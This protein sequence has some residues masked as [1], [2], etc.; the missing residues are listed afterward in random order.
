MPDPPASCTCFARLALLASPSQP[1]T[2]RSFY[3]CSW[4]PLSLSLCFHMVSPSS[5][6][7]LASP[8]CS[9]WHSAFLCVLPSLLSPSY[10]PILLALQSA[11]F[12]AVFHH[13]MLF[14]AA[15]S[16]AFFGLLR[17]REFTCSGPFDPRIHLF[18]RYF[19]HSFRIGAAISAADCER[20]SSPYLNC[21]S[22]V[23]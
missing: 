18:L 3:R 4:C 2:P 9:S 5:P 15:S 13:C 17:V 14:W 6:G 10:P 16:L 22:P 20:S 7:Y 12:L 8:S 23:P 1:A 21:W 19:S 11:F